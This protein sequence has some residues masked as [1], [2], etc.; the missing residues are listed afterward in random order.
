MNRVLLVLC[1]VASFSVLAGVVPRA[2][3]MDV[4]NINQGIQ[5]TNSGTQVQ[6][7]ATAICSPR[8]S[9]SGSMTLQVFSVADNKW[10]GRGSDSGGSLQ[11][12]P[13]DVFTECKVSPNPHDWRLRGSFK[14]GDTTYLINA[15]R[16]DLHCK[17]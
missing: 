11:S 13:L 9:V 10:E 3:A 16:E 15:H 4:C 14:A 5:R 6:G 8:A 17:A 2:H 12:L 7:Y 1:A